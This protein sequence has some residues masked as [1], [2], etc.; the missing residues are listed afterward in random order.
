[1]RFVLAK[2]FK[3]TCAHSPDCRFLYLKME[4]SAQRPD[5]LVEITQNRLELPRFVRMSIG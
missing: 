2:R 4:E 1:M 3:K 5:V